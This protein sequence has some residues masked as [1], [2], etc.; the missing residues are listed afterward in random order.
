M[1]ERAQW[2]GGKDRGKGRSKL[3]TKQQAPCGAETKRG[4]SE[5]EINQERLLT[6]GKKLGVA[7]EG[8]EDTG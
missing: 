4:K 2:E 8:W 3:P 1:K 7:V 5:R 6:L